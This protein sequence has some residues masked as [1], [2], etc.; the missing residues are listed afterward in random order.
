MKK[1]L[2]Q[3]LSVLLC[4]LL[5][6]ALAGCGAKTA[7]PVS[8]FAM[9]DRLYA[10]QTELELPNV[11]TPIGIFSDGKVDPD[12][13][14]VWKT[15]DGSYTYTYAEDGTATAATANSDT[16]TTVPFLCLERQGHNILVEELTVMSYDGEGNPTPGEKQLSYTAYLVE[17]DAMYMLSVEDI[18][19]Y[20]SSYFGTLQRFYRADEAGSIDKALAAHPVDLTSLYG[21]WEGEKGNVVIDETGLKFDG[22]VYTLSFNDKLQLVAEKDGVSTAYSFG[23]GYSKTSTDPENTQWEKH[24]ALSLNYT[25]ADENDKPNL[26]P[27]MTDWAAEYDWNEY[28]FNASFTASGNPS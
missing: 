10:T 28:L 12:L 19:E 7:A 25:G 13:I 22:A 23:V 11:E 21:E 1:H 24:R 16:L 5:V 2:K 18:G 15:A 8:L 17:G 26:L 27:C 20:S 14:G 9:I 4:V 6:C 3:A